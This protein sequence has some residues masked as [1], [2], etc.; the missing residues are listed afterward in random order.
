MESILAYCRDRQLQQIINAL[1]GGGNPGTESRSLWSCHKLEQV[2]GVETAY[3]A[4]R[5]PL[6]ITIILLQ[7]VGAERDDRAVC[8]EEFMRL[9]SPRR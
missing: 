6:P 8:R 5:V 3:P 4:K 7:G 9:P 1:H 2:S